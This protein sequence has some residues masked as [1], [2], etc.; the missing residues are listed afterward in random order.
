MKNRSS[1]GKDRLQGIVGVPQPHLE[2]EPHT[3]IIIFSSKI[4]P[5]LPRITAAKQ[6]NHET[7][8]LARTILNSQPAW[9]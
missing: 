6:L 2:L 8:R 5:A 4:Q 3:M 1:S 7:L 9:V